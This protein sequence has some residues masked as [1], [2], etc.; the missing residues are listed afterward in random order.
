M[1][2]ELAKSL[3]SGC[4][5]T[6]LSKIRRLNYDLPLLGAQGLLLVIWLLT[7]SHRLAKEIQRKFLE[8]KLDEDE[9]LRDC[10][11]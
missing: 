7:N 10:F 4:L 8:L 5:K 9:D 2:D 1:I 11:N 6:G 3:L